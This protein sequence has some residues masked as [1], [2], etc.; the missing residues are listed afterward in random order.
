V[1]RLT[2]P[3]FWPKQKN[4]EKKISSRVMESHNSWILN[5]HSP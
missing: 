3:E 2:T 1:A 4:P 5:H